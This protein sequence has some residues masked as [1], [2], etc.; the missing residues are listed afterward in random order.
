MDHV[1]RLPV[2]RIDGHD[3]RLVGS[4]DVLVPHH[5]LLHLVGHVPPPAAPHAIGEPGK[6]GPV[7]VA[8]VVGLEGEVPVVEECHVETGVDTAEPGHDIAAGQRALLPVVAGV[9]QGVAAHT[10][11]ARPVGKAGDVG[12]D[13]EVSPR[14]CGV[15]AVLAEQVVADEAVAGRSDRVGRGADGD[16]AVGPQ[17]AV[18]R[19]PLRAHAHLVVRVAEL[20]E[21]GRAGNASRGILAL[22]AVVVPVDADAEQRATDELLADGSDVREEAAELGQVAAE[23]G[24][25][26]AAEVVLGH[27]DEP[28]E[29]HVAAVVAEPAVGG[30]DA[31]V[32]P[33]RVRAVEHAQP[34]DRLVDEAARGGHGGLAC[35]GT[36]RRRT[37]EQ[38]RGRHQDR[39]QGVRGSHVP[40]SHDGYR[41]GREHARITEVSVAA[42]EAEARAPD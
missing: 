13:L 1:P 12:A 40:L 34:A 36:G 32:E 15:E 39:Y 3:R 29:R 11:H 42:A 10:D 35:L 14:Q 37:S 4:H 6:A 19:Q 26:E 41:G 9:T 31:V 30:V 22:V 23:V 33:A 16:V 28:A 27:G 38:C 20:T 24:R 7:E 18:I 21:L 5:R 8:V 17:V 2:H 25:P